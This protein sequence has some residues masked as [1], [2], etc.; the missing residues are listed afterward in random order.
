MPARQAI[1]CSCSREGKRVCLWVGKGVPGRE[2]L[3]LTGRSCHPQLQWELHGAD[4]RGPL[5]CC[6]FSSQIISICTWICT[7][8]QSD[9]IIT[10]C[11]IFGLLEY[12]LHYLIL[13]WDNVFG[14]TMR[15]SGL[16][17]PHP[18]GECC[19][20]AFQRGTLIAEKAAWHLILSLSSLNGRKI[21][22]ALIIITLKKFTPEIRE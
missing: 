7:F 9:S 19:S 15:H 13:R 12:F 11:S 10:T 14:W 8:C 18:H 20:S 4:Q 3:S 16:L 21:Q 2:H 5:S 6:S 22:G 17:A 1:L